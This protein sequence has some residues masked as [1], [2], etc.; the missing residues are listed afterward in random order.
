MQHFRQ[1]LL[2]SD[3]AELVVVPDLVDLVVVEAEAAVVVV[4][5]L[6]RLSLNPFLGNLLLYCLYRHGSDCLYRYPLPR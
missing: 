6:R 5:M 4:N 2:S 1:A 3:A